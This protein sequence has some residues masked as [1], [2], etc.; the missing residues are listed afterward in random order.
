MITKT[1]AQFCLLITVLLM[2]GSAEA[3]QQN[4]IARIGF[5]A[6]NSV[7]SSATSVEAF[8]LGLRQ[9]G[10]I[11]GQ[12][13]I[14]EWQY[15]DGRSDRLPDLAAELVRIKVDVIVTSA[16]SPTE[17]AKKATNTIP[18]VIASHNDPIGAGLVASL[19]RPGGNVT[20]LSNIAIELSGKRLELLKEM[21]PK[22]SRVAILRIPSAPATPPQM[23]EMEGAAHL[24]GVK[25]QSADW[26][27]LDDLDNAFGTMVKGHSEAL[28]TFSGP[29]FGLY[30]KRIIE[31]AA[32]NSLPTMYPDTIYADAGG[33][34][35]YGVNTVDLYRRAAIYVDKILKG[36]RPADLPVEQPTKFEFVI[37]LKTAKQI[38]LS[39]PPNILA[40]ADRVIR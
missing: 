24:L 15:A 21:V 17:A 34:M 10:Y 8:R 6:I 3:Q 31:L 11:E 32:K 19:A 40:R 2:T 30:R 12:N 5:L 14:I 26:E 39:I 25:L 22:L 7:S 13:I 29:R 16:T 35:S 36:A 20:G 27:T 4:K 37:N 18:I 38:R 28:I 33:L 23:K 9:L 1:L